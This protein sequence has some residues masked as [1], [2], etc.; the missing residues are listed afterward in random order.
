MF[1]QL[2]KFRHTPTTCAI[3]KEWHDDQCVSMQQRSEEGLATTLRKITSH[4]FC[5]CGFFSSR[6]LICCFL[7]Q[8]LHMIFSQEQVL[9][10]APMS[11]NF[12]FWFRTPAGAAD[13]NYLKKPPASWRS[14]FL[15]SRL[16]PN[17]AV[18]ANEKK[19]KV[20]VGRANAFLGV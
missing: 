17:A 20:L 2:K 18:E 19:K 7:L 5:C 6:C 8:Y 15:A 11:V 10:K 3:L 13:N 12:H 4:C 9:F 16:Q 14:T 1:T